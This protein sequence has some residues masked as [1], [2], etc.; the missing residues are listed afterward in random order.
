MLNALIAFA[1][2]FLTAGVLLGLFVW[3]YTRIT[4]YREFDLISNNNLAA[5]ISLSGAVLG[6]TFPLL[7]SIYYTQ[8]LLEMS[9]WACVTCIVQLAVFVILR[10][11]A[12]QIQN[13]HTAPA[14]MLATFSVAAGL[15][16]ALCI[17]H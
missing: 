17:S 11:Q 4:P 15:I 9:L 2:Y 1:S 3:I 6:F 16:N 13:G 12:M 8:S 10:K 7:S 14:L 5:A